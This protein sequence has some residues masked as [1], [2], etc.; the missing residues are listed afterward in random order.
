MFFIPIQIGMDIAFSGA[1]AACE[2]N[3]FYA[4][5]SLL[6]YCSN[7]SEVPLVRCRGKEDTLFQFRCLASTLFERSDLCARHLPP[8]TYQDAAS[9]GLQ[10]SGSLLLNNRC[11][12]EEKS[13]GPKKRSHP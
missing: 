10:E 11:P 6:Y 1:I 5:D 4:N 3:L 2:M 7:S 9:T 12:R 8:I 13:S